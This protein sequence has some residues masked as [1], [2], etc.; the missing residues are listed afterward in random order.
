M[1]Q[2]LLYFTKSLKSKATQDS[3]TRCL[4]EFRKAVKAETLKDLLLVAGGDGTAENN[5]KIIQK[6]IIDYL[7][8]EEQR[9]A[10]HSSRNVAYHAIKRFYEVNDV[11]LNWRMIAKYL[12]SDDRTVADRGYTQDEI[13]NC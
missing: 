8:S 2:L 9:G 4:N 13:K 6:V 11:T 5:P 3:Y 1:E 7:I 10:S 12:G